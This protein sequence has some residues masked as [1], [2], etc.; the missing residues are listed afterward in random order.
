[1][2]KATILIPAYQ[3]NVHMLS[4][5]RLLSGLGAEHILI[6]DD[7]SDASCQP[8]FTDAERYGA[9]VIHHEK[10]RGKGA[11]LKTGIR[12]AKELFPKDCGVVTADA[13][14]QH[15]PEDILRVAE[16]IPRHP[17]TL[18]L[19][20]RNFA[21]GSVP[22]KSYY[23]NRITAAFFR[24]STG[25]RLHDTQ[26][27]LRGIPKCLY[28]LALETEG[29]RYEYE[30]HFLEDSAKKI[31]FFQLPITTVYEDNNSGSHF[32]PVRDSI[33]VYERPLRFVTSSLLSSV[34]DLL[35]FWLLMQVLP[36]AAAAA[37]TAATIGSRIASSTLNYSLNRAWCFRSKENVVQSGFRYL[38]LLVVQAGASAALVTAASAIITTTLYAKIIVDVSLSVFSYY[39][40]KHWV[41][42]RKEN[43]HERHQH[44]VQ[45]TV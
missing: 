10:N 22:W 32:R 36:L 45:T 17:D 31:P 9:I 30:M 8:L 28:D 23:G 25:I 7:G 33:R 1:M 29:E 21:K 11:A 37:I 14:G 26:T 24:A 15:L 34:L 4:L 12:A 41:F 44:S 38:I 6:I 40:Q 39:A 27:G 43:R 19:G 3:P 42:R 5:V 2:T 16:A 18:I 35:L 20:V 13:D